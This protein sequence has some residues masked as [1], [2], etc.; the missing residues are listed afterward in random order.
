MKVAIAGGGNVGQHIADELS[1]NGHDVLVVEIDADLVER[2]RGA[3]QVSWFVG[4]ACEPRTLQAAGLEGCDV[5]VAA[6]GDDEDNLV[7]SLLAKQE[8]AVPRV[9]A[10]NNHPK[11]RWLF[12]ESWGVDVS[13]STPHLLTALVSEAVSVGTLVRLLELEGGDASLIEVT[14]A[15][16]SPA[17]DARIVDLNFPREASV[18]AV[19]R[20]GHVVV[21]RGDTVLAAGDEVMVLVTGD[22]E[23]LVTTSLVGQSSS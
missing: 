9:V 23:A 14:L 19:V 10:R 3:H 5:M 12:N 17:V 2:V 4:D 11:N 21:P 15:G 8:F 13:V 7:I 6:T 20:G 22:S 18:V 16:D 1:A